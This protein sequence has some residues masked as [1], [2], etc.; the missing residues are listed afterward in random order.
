MENLFW[1]RVWLWTQV[2]EVFVQ[3]FP[4]W[5]FEALRFNLFPDRYWRPM[6]WRR[7]WRDAR[8]QRRN[9]LLLVH[10]YKDWH[11]KITL[12][13]YRTEVNQMFGINPQ[14]QENP[15]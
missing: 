10:E 6:P 1:L 2:V 14:T 9:W 11:R 7:V 8:K 15:T 13:Q 12:K 3:N 4:F 5:A